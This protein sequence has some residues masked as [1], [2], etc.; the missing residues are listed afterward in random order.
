MLAEQLGQLVANNFHHLLVG[1]KLDHHFATQRL[2]AD[3]GEQLVG[4]AEGHVAF[5]QRLADLRQRGVEMLLG[6]LPLSAKVLERALQLLGEVLKHA[7]ILGD[8][9]GAVNA[10]RTHCLCWSG[11][12]SLARGLHGASSERKRFASFSICFRFPFKS[13]G[14]CPW[15][16]WSIC[17]GTACESL[18]SSAACW[19]NCASS[20]GLRF[21]SRGGSS[22]AFV[23]LSAS[24]MPGGIGRP[25]FPKPADTTPASSRTK[26]E[27]FRMR[28]PA[29]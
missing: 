1:R 28:P 9:N 15:A 14:N 6:Q 17:W 18:A 20:A 16:T 8:R 19:R 7:S 27:S 26:K 11:P 24:R 25:C 29:E 3:V 13:F 5:E 23:A 2:A 12:A 21:I 10:R 4:H 22:G